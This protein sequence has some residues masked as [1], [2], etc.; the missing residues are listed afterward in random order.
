M[1][2]RHGASKVWVMSSTRVNGDQVGGSTLHSKSG[3]HRGQ[4]TVQAILGK[5]KAVVKRGWVAVRAIRLDEV[6][7]C[8]ADFMQLFD[9]WR[10]Q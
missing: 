1:K 8:S 4:G 6:S 10:K 5:M 3:L 7:M 9:G 2:A